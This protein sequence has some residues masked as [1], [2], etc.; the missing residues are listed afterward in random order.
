MTDDEVKAWLSDEERIDFEEAIYSSDTRMQHALES[1]A[2]TRKALAH[3]ESVAQYVVDR[4]MAEVKQPHCPDVPG[5][6][7]GALN[8]VGGVLKTMPRPR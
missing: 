7:R 4:H 3:V 5:H 1:L 8:H 6:L 2:E